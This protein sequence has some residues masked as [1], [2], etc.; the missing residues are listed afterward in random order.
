MC[1]GA[2]ILESNFEIV[3]SQRTRKGAFVAMGKPKIHPKTQLRLAEVW[4]RKHPE[5][6]NVSLFKT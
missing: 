3:Y 2:F 6:L 1:A 4:K 5:L